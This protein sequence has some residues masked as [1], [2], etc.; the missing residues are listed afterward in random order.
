MKKIIFSFLLLLL[1]SGAALAQAKKT[2][3]APKAEA[4]VAKTYTEE[5]FHKELVKAVAEKLKK[6]GNA[7]I[8]DFSTELL[9]RERQLD[10]KEQDIQKREDTLSKMNED[11]A[12]QIKEFGKKQNDFL[13][14]LDGIEEK[15]KTRL[16]HM[17]DVIS[18]MKPAN[19]AEVLSVQEA[20]IS[21]KILGELDPTKV[22]KIFNLMDK[23]ISARLQKQ[24]LTMK[25]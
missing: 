17:V 3:D 22:S 8:V 25:K 4:K 11:F 13:S 14:C 15:E 19:A 2:K 23:E 12:T 10:V 16:T 6:V 24:Y 18:G 5:E 20:S 1:F 9:E 21:V 7:K